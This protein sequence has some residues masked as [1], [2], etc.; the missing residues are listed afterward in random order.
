M[1]LKDDGFVERTD[2]IEMTKQAME[3]SAEDV[4]SYFR[5]FNIE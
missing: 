5:E 3:L 1:D 2:L 4:D